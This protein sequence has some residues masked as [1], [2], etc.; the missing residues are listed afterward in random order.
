MVSLVDVFDVIV[1]LV[2]VSVWNCVRLQFSMSVSIVNT[3]VDCL[4]A[5]AVHKCDN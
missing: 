4:H 3:R 2:W 1:G 5:R